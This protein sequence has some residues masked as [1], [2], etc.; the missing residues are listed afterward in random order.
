MNCFFLVEDPSNAN[1]VIF[2]MVGNRAVQL[3]FNPSSQFIPQLKLYSQLQLSLWSD[4]ITFSV[5]KSTW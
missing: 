3:I 4:T 2:D 1:I 5:P